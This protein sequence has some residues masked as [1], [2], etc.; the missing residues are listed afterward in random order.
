M[1]PSRGLRVRTQ[2]TTVDQFVTWFSAYCNLNS[3]FLPTSVLSPLGSEVPFSLDLADGTSAFA[4]LGGVLETWPTAANRFGRP[5][6]MIE[7]RRLAQASAP[8]FERIK[9]AKTVTPVDEF[10][11]ATEIAAPSFDEKIAQRHISTE[12][13]DLRSAPIEK[14]EMVD[15]AARV[16]KPPVLPSQED[17][18]DEAAFTDDDQP[19]T[20]A[21]DSDDSAQRGEDA[22]VQ[23][24]PIA[25]ALDISI[26]SEA[27]VHEPPAVAVA[28]YETEPATSVREPSINII[29]EAPAIVPP[30]RRRRWP[31]ALAIIGVLAV[32]ATVIVV[33]VDPSSSAPAPDA[34]PAVVP[35]PAPLDAAPPP[36]DA[37]AIPIDAAAPAP[38]PAAKPKHKPVKP[39]K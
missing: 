13:W 39:R 2:C 32:A 23:M 19:T 28:R 20:L 38:P 18:P 35:P 27:P 4:G 14:V 5:G 11:I 12:V 6:M 36:P 37:A 7:V 17:D 1:A 34:A 10:D 8:I 24:A 15:V 33:F 9:Q 31:I 22:Y 25:D 21:Q 30:P 29:V 16:P 3:F 26:P